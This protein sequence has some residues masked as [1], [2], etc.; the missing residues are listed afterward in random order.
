M[1]TRKIGRND[2]SS[3]DFGLEGLRW[4]NCHSKE[5]IRRAATSGHKE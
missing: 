3:K 2:R 5:K 1:P 4:K